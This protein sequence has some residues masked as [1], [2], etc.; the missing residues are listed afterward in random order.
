MITGRASPILTQVF[1]LVL[2]CVL[3]TL[4]LGLG[5][6]A[7]SPPPSPSTFLINSFV[8]AYR[9]GSNEVVAV[10]RSREPPRFWRTPSSQ[11]ETLIGASVAEALGKRPDNVRVAMAV[12]TLFGLV[13]RSEVANRGQMTIIDVPH[14]LRASPGA[15]PFSMSA[16][17]RDERVRVPPFL[18]AISNADGSWSVLRPREALPTPWHLRIAAVFFLALVVVTP[19]AWLGARRWTRPVRRLAER[20][21]QFDGQSV[22][23][24]ACRSSDAAELQALERA[25]DALRVRIADQVEQR[26]AMLMAVVHDLRTPLTSL[27]VRSE[28]AP[29]EVRPG[30]LRDIARVEKMIDGILNFASTRAQREDDAP[31]DFQSV[32]REAAGMLQRS[33]ATVHTEI[34]SVWILGNSIELSRAVDNVLQN[35]IRYGSKIDVKLEHEGSMALLQ[36]RDDGPGVPE[37][38]IPKLTDPFF[39]VE[40]SRSART[41]GLGLGLATTNAIVAAHGGSLDFR[42]LS[43][44]FEVC[45]AIPLYTGTMARQNPRCS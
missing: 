44:G 15:A 34:N 5:V 28:D 45:L 14:E 6:V 8:E 35:A 43:R 23:S 36:V 32:V 39:R 41:G 38:L 10:A 30:M 33:G 24:P 40:T 9:E 12:P 37:E 13:A 18:A 17:L 2:I 27:R 21:D 3:A 16:L 7:L 26:T 20:V 1:A 25:F 11:P 42:N 19:L 22:G 4:A 31:I 29:L